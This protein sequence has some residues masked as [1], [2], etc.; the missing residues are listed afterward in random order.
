MKPT[1]FLRIAS[2]LVLIFCAGHTTGT[3]SPPAPGV[4]TMV[5]QTMKANSF[6]AMGSMRTFWDFLFG[7]GLILSIF[8]LAH[9]FLFWQLGSLA[10]TDAWRLRPVFVILALEFLAQAPVAAH[11]FFIGPLIGSLLIA[12]CLAAAFFTARSGASA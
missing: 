1:L 7:Y 10:K 11:Y 8:L 5:V 9:C 3:F 4:Q 2:I 12:A 6:N